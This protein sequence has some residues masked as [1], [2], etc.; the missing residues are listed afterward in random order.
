[1]PPVVKGIELGSELT[2]VVTQLNQLIETEENR[3]R[4]AGIDPL[5]LRDATGNLVLS[6]LV[7][8]KATALQGLALI[9][10]R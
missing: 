4:S 7:T 5:Q 1:M 2:K 3:A 10:Q 6:P 8:A 9:N